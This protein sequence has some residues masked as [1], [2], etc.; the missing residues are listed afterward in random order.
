MT[1]L[2]VKSFSSFLFVSDHS[3][4]FY[5]IHDFC[6]YFCFHIRTCRGFAVSIC[7]QHFQFYFI[8]SFTGN[9]RHIQSLVFFDFELLSGYFNYCD[10]SL[11]IREAKVRGKVE[12]ANGKPKFYV[13]KMKPFVPASFIFVSPARKTGKLLI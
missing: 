7:H 6:F 8:T 9:M 3:I 4:T 2:F 5:V 1:F 13:D 10:H 11:K 12:A